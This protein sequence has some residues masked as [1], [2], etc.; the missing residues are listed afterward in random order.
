MNPKFCAG[1]ALIW[2]MNSTIYFV[3]DK[4]EDNWLGYLHGAN[5]VMWV[6][7]AG[8]NAQNRRKENKKDDKNDNFDIM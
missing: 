5:A 7:L 6:G 3:N 2:A 8:M 4:P 1:L